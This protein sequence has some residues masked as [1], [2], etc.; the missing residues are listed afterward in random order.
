M[1]QAAYSNIR[2]TK[3]A[4]L[5]RLAFVLQQ[6]HQSVLDQDKQDRS[7]YQAYYHMLIKTLKGSKEA[8]K[9]K[10]EQPDK[11]SSHN[12]ENFDE[13]GNLSEIIERPYEESLKISSEVLIESNEDR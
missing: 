13:R 10:M 12:D 7:K 1:Q 4:G 2:V 5:Y 6:M 11:N 9:D 3:Q 8:F